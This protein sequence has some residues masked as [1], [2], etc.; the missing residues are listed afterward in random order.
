MK[1]TDMNIFEWLEYG[2]KRGFCS[3]AVC[4]THD[5]LP[6]TDEEN[7]EWDEGGDPCVHAVRLYQP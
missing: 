2:M 7:V 3:E 5:G 6:M 1:T 4:N